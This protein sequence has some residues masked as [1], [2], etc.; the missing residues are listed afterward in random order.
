MHAGVAELD[1]T[2]AFRMHG[3]GAFD[4]DG[5]KLVGAAF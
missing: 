3:H 1:E 5:A 4:G 2:G